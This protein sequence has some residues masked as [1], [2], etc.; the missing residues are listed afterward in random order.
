MYPIHL[1]VFIRL[2]VKHS[3]LN[4]CIYLCTSVTFP[5]Y[6][7]AVGLESGRILLYRW[8][9]DQEPATGNDWT[10]CGQTDVSYPFTAHRPEG[11]RCARRDVT[12]SVRQPQFDGFD[13]L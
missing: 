1:R 5:S 13:V 12:A 2:V 9:P 3:T 7:L 11:L 6:L 4:V 8:S 10:S